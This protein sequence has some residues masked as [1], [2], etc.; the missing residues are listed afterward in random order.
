M[1]PMR[2]IKRFLPV[3]AMFAMAFA[4]VVNSAQ[5]LMP[6]GPPAW[7]SLI[8]QTKQQLE[9][10]DYSAAKSS[11]EEALKLSRT[12]QTSDPRLGT[13]YHYLGNLYLKEQD[14]SQA[15]E[16]FLRAIPIEQ[17]VVGADSL[18]VADAMFGLANCY[19][20]G[21]NA[22]LA[23]VYIKP[24]VDISSKAYGPES[25]TLLSV[26]PSFAT[27]ASLNSNYKLSEETYRRIL[28]IKEKTYGAADPRLGSTLNT[29]SSIAASEGNYQEA[30]ALA[31]RA[32]S[33][34]SKSDSSTVAYDSAV[35]N[36]D[37][38]KQ[39]LGEK[40]PATTAAAQPPAQEKPSTSPG[41]QTT[42]ATGEG[43]KETGRVAA[44]EPAAAQAVT[45][46]PDKP[47]PSV[48]TEHFVRVPNAAPVTTSTDE[49]RPWELKNQTHETTSTGTPGRSTS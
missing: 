36:L 22:M 9:S 47:N 37:Y 13:M 4:L 27:Y 30:K 6:N 42:I 17:K 1:F 28:R 41:S 21:G 48:T 11:L 34:L 8:G 29:L 5:P 23:E 32:T 20:R 15:G 14:Y 26:L 25:E 46:K 12:F 31:E 24:V 45:P 18:D 40:Q 2:N 19:Q 3:G 16:Y 7:D 43:S 44:Q 38:I 10:G 49:F 35:A 33:V 39:R